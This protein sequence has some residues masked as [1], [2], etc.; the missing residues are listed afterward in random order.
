MQAINATCTETGK[1]YSCKAS[2]QSLSLCGMVYRVQRERARGREK[3]TE[4][5]V[6]TKGESEN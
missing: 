6:K 1:S 5:T 4:G 3:K 2:V